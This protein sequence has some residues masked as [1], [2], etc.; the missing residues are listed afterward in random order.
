MSDERTA[1]D[2]TKILTQDACDVTVTAFHKQGETDVEGCLA[3]EMKRRG[4][5]LE[6]PSRA[7]ELAA[8]IRRG[9]RVV[10]AG[11]HEDVVFPEAAP[12][13]AAVQKAPK[14]R[15]WPFRRPRAGAGGRPAVDGTQGRGNEN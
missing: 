9:E 3:A 7:A 8:M 5:E 10:V 2:R 13:V 12:P 11:G 14:R 6:E 4:F 15:F 1:D